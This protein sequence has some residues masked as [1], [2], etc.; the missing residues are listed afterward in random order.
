L[1]L[2]VCVL[3][4]AKIV[5]E[6]EVQ[7]VGYRDFVQKVAKRLGVRGYVENLDDGNVLVVGEADGLVLDDFLGKINVQD[8]LMLV[9]KVSVV[10][11][12]DV[13][14]EFLSFKIKYG[15][16]EDEL[17]ERLGTAVEV[18]KATRSDIRAMHGDVKGTR[19][20][21]KAMHDDVRGTRSD[22][23][24]MH[25]DVKG[26]RSDIASMNENLS[27]SIGKM[28]VDL[29]Q[30]IGSM[31]TDVAG[32][33]VGVQ[34]EVGGMRCEMNDRFGEMAK[35][36]DVISGELVRTREE[37]TRAVDGLLKVIEEFIHK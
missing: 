25:E 32:K 34:E 11:R 26:T 5:V 3:I 27:G 35:R 18:A 30:S 33:V 13:A 4:R 17:G 9:E 23:K 37:L 19:L 1:A 14:G 31:H 16:L 28:N 24:A 8:D 10:E 36:Y 22:I 15:C 6:G 12:F 29:N 20:D 7:K 21:I 2:W